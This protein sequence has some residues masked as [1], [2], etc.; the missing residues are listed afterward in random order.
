MIKDSISMVGLLYIAMVA[1]MLLFTAQREGISHDAV[2]SAMVTSGQVSTMQGLDNS[3]RTTSD[4]V[5]YRP[6]NLKNSLKK[7][8]I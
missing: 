8:Y 4:A 1:L 6:I 7:R 3:A 2:V 5:L